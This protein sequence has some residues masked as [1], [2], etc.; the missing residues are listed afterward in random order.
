M[1]AP[2]TLNA[3]LKTA[4]HYYDFDTN[5]LYITKAY[6]KKAETYGTPECN[7][8]N[9]MMAKFP[10]MKMLLSMMWMNCLI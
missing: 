3:A 10:G 4:G 6:L 1:F 8:L 5:I 2:S 9:G 7:N